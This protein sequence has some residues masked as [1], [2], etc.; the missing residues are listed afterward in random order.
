MRADRA[1]PGRLSLLW[2]TL[3]LGM[4]T[5]LLTLLLERAGEPIRGGGGGAWMAP[6]RRGRPAAL[7][8]LPRECR[9]RRRML[10]ERGCERGATGGCELGPLP[11]HPRP[12]AVRRRR[13]VL[14]SR[15]PGS[16]ALCAA[17]R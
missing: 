14:A 17:L 15:G 5:Q 10:A 4:R 12:A 2:H 6:P 1:C 3:A 7:A 9:R 16:P 11:R 8:L 13:R